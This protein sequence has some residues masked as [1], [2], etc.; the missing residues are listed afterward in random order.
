MAG[1]ILVS[2]VLFARYL[3][4]QLIEGARYERI[5]AR[6]H[7]DTI[8]ISGRRGR[9]YDRL[10]RLL[11]VNSSSCSILVWPRHIRELDRNDPG[12]ATR[13]SISSRRLTPGLAGMPRA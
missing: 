2:G 13:S 9:M 7:R 5:A 4:V 8:E 3:Q 6:M 1:I 10:G 11:T 12:V